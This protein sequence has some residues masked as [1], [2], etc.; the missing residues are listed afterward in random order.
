MRFAV[1]SGEG[2]A[3]DSTRRIVTMISERF[4]VVEFNARIPDADFYVV[5]G[6]RASDIA[7]AL[8]RERLREL[9]DAVKTEGRGYIGICA[10]AYLAMEGYWTEI[11]PLDE[12]VLINV[13]HPDIERW[14]RGEGWVE[15]E[16][17][18]E[19]NK[20]WYENG[21]VFSEGDYEVLGIFRGDVNEISSPISLISTPAVI[22][23]GRVLLFSPHPE[24]S[25]DEGKRVFFKTLEV[26]L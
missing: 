26:I 6:G 7:N 3:E 9:N 4:E 14:N 20:L 13:R 25:G 15:V 10:G 16:I 17:L 18:G 22:R 12:L 24:L 19:K 23:K 1:Y 8:G 11:A 21:P 2:S 5:G